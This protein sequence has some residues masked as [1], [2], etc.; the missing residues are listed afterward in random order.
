[1]GCSI[2]NTP[3]LQRRSTTMAHLTEAEKIARYDAERDGTLYVKPGADTVWAD[4]LDITDDPTDAGD[5]PLSDAELRAIE[6]L[7]P[8]IRIIRSRDQAHRQERLIAILEQIAAM[9]EPRQ[10]EM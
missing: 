6:I 4:V 7:Y 2:S 9:D 10:S 1:M 8:D 3:N 5:T